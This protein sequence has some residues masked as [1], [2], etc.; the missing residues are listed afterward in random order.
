MVLLKTQYL[1]VH[2]STLNYSACVAYIVGRDNLPWVKCHLAILSEVIEVDHSYDANFLSVVARQ[3]N[4][5]RKRRQTFHCCSTFVTS[6]SRS[7]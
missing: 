4:Q 5:P 1:Y 7:L 6:P 3:Q 2:N